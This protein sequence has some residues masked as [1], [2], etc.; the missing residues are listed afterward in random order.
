M[1]GS[2]GPYLG[3]EGK[4]SFGPCIVD[5]KIPNYDINL[6]DSYFEIR[7]RD[8]SPFYT[9]SNRFSWED[10]DDL[11]TTTI[12]DTSDGKTI[13]KI[14]RGDCYICNFTHRMIR[15]F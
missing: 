11:S 5:I 15:N 7:F 12:N 13:E 10:I 9:I 4:E 6:M 2:F 3:V 1:R 14:F 8:S